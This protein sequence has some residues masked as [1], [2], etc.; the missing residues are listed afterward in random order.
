MWLP[1]PICTPGPLYSL[2]LLRGSMSMRSEIKHFWRD[3]AGQG[4]SEY[5]LLLAGVV[6]L[7][8]VATVMY[9]G[10]ITKLFTG[11]GNYMNGFFGRS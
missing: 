2:G 3:E 1:W 4:A 7:V 11:I 8:V 10:E 6:V 5:A 9:D